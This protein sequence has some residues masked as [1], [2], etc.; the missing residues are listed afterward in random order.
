MWEEG[1]NNSQTEVLAHRL[2]DYYG[3]RLA[4]SPNLAAAQDWLVETYESWGVPVRKE[5][6]GT[7]NGWQQGTLHVDM[8][9]P[10]VRTM[11]THL[12]A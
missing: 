7:W 1:I 12:L 9:E 4:G 11:E 6:Y 8:L 3:P 5:E 2:I 10:R